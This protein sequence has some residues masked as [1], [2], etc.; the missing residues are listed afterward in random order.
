[1]NYVRRK[2]GC[3]NFLSSVGLRDLNSTNEGWTCGVLFNAMGN[4]LVLL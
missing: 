2:K 1:M 3:K 4:S